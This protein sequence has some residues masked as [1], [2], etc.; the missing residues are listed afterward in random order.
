MSMCKS[1]IQS[2][3]EAVDYQQDIICVKKTCLI[4]KSVEYFYNDDIKQ[5]HQRTGL[6]QVMFTVCFGI[7]PKTIEAW[8]N[9][10][11]KPKGSSCRLLEIVSDKPRFLKRF[12]V[13]EY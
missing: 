10:R 9:G 6:R 11:I 13:D 5:I 8:E 7:S 4:V 2:L 3:I 1:I 12:Q